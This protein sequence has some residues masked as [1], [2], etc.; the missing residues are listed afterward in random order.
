MFFNKILKLDNH[1]WEKI[2]IYFFVEKN[3]AQISRVAV[4][5]KAPS[6][7]KKN[8]RKK[9]PSSLFVQIRPTKRCAEIFLK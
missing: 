4:V 5:K 9:N 7:W 3:D 6:L 8:F 1:P 2:K